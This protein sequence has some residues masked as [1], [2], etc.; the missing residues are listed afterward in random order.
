MGAKEGAMARFSRTPWM[1]RIAGMSNRRGS[2]RPPDSSF[3]VAPAAEA[4][5]GLAARSLPDLPAL[6]VVPT[7]ADSASVD[8]H[9]ASAESS[10]VHEAFRRPWPGLRRRT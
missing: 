9:E 7:P 6:P 2:T 10:V 4:A 1:S 5:D 8:V 3:W